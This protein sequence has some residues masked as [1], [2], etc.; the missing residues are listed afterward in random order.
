MP[1]YSSYNPLGN[2]IET[3]EITAGAITADKLGTG[4]V[5][6]AKLADN[7]VTDDKIS[8]NLLNRGQLEIIEL[9]ANTSVTPID[10]DSMILETFSD[11]DG[12]NNL[13]NTGNTTA[14]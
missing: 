9:Q 4:A 12:Y 5:T 6:N 3:T 7:A 10:H 8:S 13:V 1:K 11:A 14:H 2:S